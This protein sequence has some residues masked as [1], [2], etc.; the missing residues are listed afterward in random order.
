[1]NKL[2]VFN[3]EEFGQVR[4]VLQGED[5][6][7]VAKDVTDV[8]ELKSAKDSTKYL[9]DDE[10]DKVLIKH[11][12][13]DYKSEMMVVN[14]SGLYSLILRSR[15]PQAKAFKK[16]VTSEVL[17][18]IRKHGAYMTDQALEKAVTDPDFMI[19]LLTNLKEEKQKRVEAERK[20]LQQQPLV[21]FAEAVKVSINSI[22]VKDL[23]I[24]LK[25]KGIDTGQNRLFGWL[26]E[27]GYLC[28][29][30]GSMY[31]SPT[32]RSMDMGL[33]ERQ[34]YVRTNSN[35]EFETRFTSK[36]TGKGQLYFINK[37]LGKEAM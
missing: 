11:S 22:L 15:K 35:G 17:P 16:W 34:P 12:G 27:N 20:V 29:K 30:E 33:F 5:V 9:D 13:S 2:Q 3:N 23:A 28:S 1:M 19:G 37:F 25:Q 26:R 10:K 21:T 32:Q 24:L 14:E 8:L 4:T 36:V 7:F 6:W 31:N 18:S